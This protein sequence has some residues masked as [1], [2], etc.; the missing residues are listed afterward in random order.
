MYLF[1][2]I[3]LSGILI[4]KKYVINKSS[5]KLKASFQ[6]ANKIKGVGL[7]YQMNGWPTESEAVGRGGDYEER[8]N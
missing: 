3:Y 2:F 1:I 6:L 4:F 5:S 7:S 8:K